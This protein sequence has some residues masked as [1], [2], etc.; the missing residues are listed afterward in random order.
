MQN[1]SP[2]L[3]GIYSF[4]HHVLWSDLPIQLWQKE[5]SLYYRGNFLCKSRAVN[6][7]FLTTVFWGPLKYLKTNFNLSCRI[8]IAPECFK[9]R[10]KSSPNLEVLPLPWYHLTTFTNLENNSKWYFSFH[11]H[12]LVLCLNVITTNKI[13]NCRIDQWS[14]HC[15]ALMPHVTWIQRTK[16]GWLNS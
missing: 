6:F 9:Y 16:L 2:L 14:L 11:V 15:I 4:W 5:L 13:W 7:L 8:R 12:G 10:C 3:K 1:I